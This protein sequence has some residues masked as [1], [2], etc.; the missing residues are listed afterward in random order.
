MGNARSSVPRPHTHIRTHTHIQTRRNTAMLAALGFLVGEQFHPL[1][2]G[3]ID[4]PSYLA[5]QQTPLETF[6]PAVVA[7]IAIPEVASFST[8]E[9]PK[10]QPWS[11]KTDREA[12]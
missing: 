9:S 11:T 4:V 7:A 5:F 2:G 12:G 1:F 3:N 8:F 6:W 10:G